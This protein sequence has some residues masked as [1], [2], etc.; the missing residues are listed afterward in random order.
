MTINFDKTNDVIIQRIPTKH[1]NIDLPGVTN[2]NTIKLTLV[3]LSGGGRQES[4]LGV[5]IGE[6]LSIIFL[7]L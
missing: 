7:K 6:G 5:G 2:Q 1:S 4:S 3:V